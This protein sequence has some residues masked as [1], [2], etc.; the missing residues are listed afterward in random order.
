MVVATT[1]LLLAGIVA[2]PAAPAD[3][4][5]HPTPVATSPVATGEKCADKASPAASTSL[6]GDSPQ[7]VARVATLRSFGFGGCEGVRPGAIL[8][9]PH[10]DGDRVCTANFLFRGVDEHRNT[11]AYIGTAG[12]C[13][14]GEGLFAADSGEKTWPL[15]QGPEVQSLDGRR[16]GEFAYA[17]ER[18]DPVRDFALVRLDAGAPAR[19]DMCHFGGPTAMNNDVSTTLTA[20]HFYGHGDIVSWGV[21][22]RTIYATSM[23][24]PEQV[25]A[26]GISNR[27]DSG[28]GV[29]TSDGRAVGLVVTLGPQAYLRTRNPE[30]G[31]I[32]IMRIGPHIERA[33]KVLRQ[34]LQLR[35]APLR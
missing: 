14:L 30:P 16:I 19:P 23:T 6:A 33:E 4:A 8:R 11:H 32:G 12:H 27:G 35:T 28:A 13:I 31:F 2:P 15:G 29:I 24:S 21:P 20:L 17:I 9:I 7:L 1:L 10:P 5:G 26:V 3:P 34:D 25:Q 18:R 22:A